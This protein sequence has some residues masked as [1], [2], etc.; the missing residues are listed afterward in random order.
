[1]RNEFVVERG[2]L[3]RYLGKEVHVVVPDKVKTIG[4]YAFQR[5]SEILSVQLPG[6]VTKISDS[7]FK[8]CVSLQSIKIPENVKTIGAEAFRNCR[9][10][11]TITFAGA[12]EKIGLLA[13]FGCW[14]LAKNA[15]ALLQDFFVRMRAGN[16][17]G[18]EGKKLYHFSKA[19]GVASIKEFDGV[20]MLTWDGNKYPY[21]FGNRENSL[22]IPLS[23]GDLPVVKAPSK[24]IPEN[25]V[26]YCSGEHFDK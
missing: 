15:P 7:A 14:K 12:P 20:N 3:E 2:T 9:Q 25:A 10:L 5:H 11:D 16:V 1:M 21:A 26:V 22:I 24:Q 8:D 19:K 17:D 18:E 4:S 6:S 13:F 23:I